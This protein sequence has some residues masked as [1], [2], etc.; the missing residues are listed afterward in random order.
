MKEPSFLEKF[1][2]RNGTPYADYIA[3]SMELDPRRKGVRI[4]KIRLRST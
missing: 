2:C 4:V 3:A 1:T